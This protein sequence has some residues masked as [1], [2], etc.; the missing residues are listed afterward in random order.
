MEGGPVHRKPRRRFVPLVIAAGVALA[1]CAG[2]GGP[3]TGGPPAAAPT[4]RVGDRWVYHAEDGYRVKTV[5]D[6]THEIVAIGPDGITM[7]VTAKGPST[8]VVRT[9]K[10]SAPGVVLV[11]SVYE[12]ETDRFDPALIR[13]KFPLAP[14]ESWQQRIRDL[15]KPPGPYGPIVRHVS[16]D[17]YETITTAAGTFEALR[18][19]VIMTLDDETFWR[20]ATECNDLVWYAPAVAAVVREH[21]QSKWRQKDENGAAVYNPGQNMDVT[22][23]SFTRGP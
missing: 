7:R 16:V 3:V 21:N 1:G 2:G 8:D 20:S 19:R 5:W 14:G 22:L 12:Q 6:E 4:Y 9:E 23:V 11:G 13:Y 15:D 17:G 18:M 10:W